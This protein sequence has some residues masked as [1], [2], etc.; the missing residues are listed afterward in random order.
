MTTDLQDS[1]QRLTLAYQMKEQLREVYRSD[2]EE[3][4]E[5]QL[6]AWCMEAEESGISQ[7]KKMAGTLRKHW[8]GVLA[9]WEEGVTSAKIEGF[10]TKIR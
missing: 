2:N 1:N 10:N 6:S 3:E 4:A 8:A 5:K 9:Y 7:L